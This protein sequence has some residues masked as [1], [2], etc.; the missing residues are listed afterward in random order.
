MQWD[1]FPFS[2]FDTQFMVAGYDCTFEIKS[3]YGAQYWFTV[4]VLCRGSKVVDT[5]K[6]WQNYD[7]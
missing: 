4:L 5:P 2:V 3:T 6:Q 7:F 1:F